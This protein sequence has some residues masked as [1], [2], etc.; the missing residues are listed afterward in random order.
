MSH[1]QRAAYIALGVACAAFLALETVATL[2]L[3]VAYP[4]LCGGATDVQTTLYKVTSIIL[5]LGGALGTAL[6]IRYVAK[7]FRD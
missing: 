5:V 2:W 7:Q 1:T 4:D 6:C 3:V